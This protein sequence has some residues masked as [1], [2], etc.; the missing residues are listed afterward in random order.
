MKL[1]NA[2]YKRKGKESFNYD[3]KKRLQWNDT[4]NA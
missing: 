1:D 3:G 2:P 4:D